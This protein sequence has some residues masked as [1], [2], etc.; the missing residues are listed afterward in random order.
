MKRIDLTVELDDGSTH[1]I[2]VANPS[3]VAWDRVRGQRKWP[4]TEEAP[5]LWMTF[6]A[7]HHM[8]A[9]GLVDCDYSE[10]EE[11]RCV[12]IDGGDEEDQADEDPTPPA[13]EAG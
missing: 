5:S 4:T 11:T 3:L 6:I 10:F 13:P 9:L 12:G 7:W 1:Q 2:K 8:K